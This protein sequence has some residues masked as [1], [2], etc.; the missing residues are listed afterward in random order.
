MRV[1]GIP[2]ESPQ[3]TVNRLLTD[4]GAVARLA[5]A[6][7]R[8]LDRVLELGEEIAQIGHEVLAIAERLDRRA[9]AIMAL[10]ERLDRRAEAIMLLGERLDSRAAELIEMGD[11]IQELGNRIDERGGEI[12]DRAALV[13]ETGSELIAVL[14]AFER[15]LEMATPLEGAIDRFGRLVDRLPGGAQRRRGEPPTPPPTG[16]NDEP[17][18]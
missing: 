18:T 15:A 13:V 12:V 7:P 1:L 5:R 11:G 2:I 16:E 3:A 17:G 4:L 6:A 8:Q 14:P 10:G 9:G